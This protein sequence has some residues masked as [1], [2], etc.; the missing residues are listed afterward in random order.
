LNRLLNR[1]AV[2]FFD[3]TSGRVSWTFDIERA[4]PVFRDS[5]GVNAHVSCTYNEA[6]GRFFLVTMHTKLGLKEGLGS[7]ANPDKC[8]NSVL[9]MTASL[10]ACWP[11]PPRGCITRRM[12]R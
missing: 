6:L 10:C 5:R 9:D 8:E 2:G 12:S 1:D 4:K 7:G 3:G 11:S